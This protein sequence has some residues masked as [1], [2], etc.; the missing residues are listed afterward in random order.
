M[1]TYEG[2]RLLLRLLTFSWLKMYMDTGVGWLLGLREAVAVRLKV[3][4]LMK[5][6]PPRR[7]A[8]PPPPAQ[9]AVHK[10]KMPSC[11]MSMDEVAKT[12]KIT[13]VRRM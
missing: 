1:A 6:T 13:P 3:C 8:S 5:T 9:H 12:Y 4:N 2:Q 10:I 7:K 11:H